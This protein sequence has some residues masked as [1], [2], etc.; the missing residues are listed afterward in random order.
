MDDLKNS[1]ALLKVASEKRIF[2]LYSSYMS[3]K[4]GKLRTTNDHNYMCLDHDIGYDGDVNIYLF[5]AILNKLDVQASIIKEKDELIITSEGYQS[6]LTTLDTGFPE[7][8]MPDC[9]M[10]EIDEAFVNNVLMASKFTAREIDGW[11]A[12]VCVD[13]DNI[14]GMSL[15]SAPVFHSTHNLNIPETLGL[16]RKVVQTLAPGTSIGISDGNLVVKYGELGFGIF[17]CLPMKD[18]PTTA[19]LDFV[20]ISKREATSVGFVSELSNA[21]GRVVPIFHGEAQNV[22]ILKNKADTPDG[23]VLNIYGAS[24]YNGTSQVDLPNTCDVDFSM[25]L[26][27]P[28]LKS[29]PSHY[30]FGYRVKENKGQLVCIHN[31]NTIIVLGEAV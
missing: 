10:T 7:K 24:M 4:D 25:H 15:Y 20:N 9:P 26:S 28:K 17:S 12:Y 16:S 5:D 30:T 31:N 3:S 8:D 23:P 19:L 1:V 18:Y 27:V 13:Q 2:P 22:V 6:K 11:K 21:V 29:V 14:Y